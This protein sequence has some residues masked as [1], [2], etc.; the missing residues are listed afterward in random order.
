MR[1][2][3]MTKSFAVLC[4]GIEEEVGMGAEVGIEE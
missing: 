1:A 2:A 4:N 3:D